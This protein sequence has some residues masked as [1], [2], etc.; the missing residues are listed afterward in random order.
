EGD[1]Y[2]HCA[3]TVTMHYDRSSGVL[4]HTSVAFWCGGHGFLYP[5]KQPPRRGGRLPAV[6]VAEPDPSRVVCATCAGRSIGSGQQGTHK[7]G[8]S[9]VKYRP[10]RP[11]IPDRSRRLA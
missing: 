7:I 11:F 5:N 9:F 10:R 8:D 4:T 6:M 2:V 3:K 1:G